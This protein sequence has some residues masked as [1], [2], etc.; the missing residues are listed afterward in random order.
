MSM[1][2]YDFPLSANCW[3]VRLVLSVY[4]VAYERRT[5]DLTRGAHLSREYRAVNP[6]GQTPALVADGEV[7]RDS[8]VICL[9]LGERFGA[10]YWPADPQLRRAIA[11]WMFFD[12]SDLH[13]GVGLARN[14]YLFGVGADGDGPRARGERALGAMERTLRAQP[15]LCGENPTLAD[16][17]C[18]PFAALM[19]EARIDPAGFPHVAAWRERIAALPGYAPMT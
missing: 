11:A 15:W 2:L 5:V 18:Y 12:A 14:H 7:I 9:Y 10:P 19:H 1:I 4:G 16:L 6:L 13:G 3:R 8:H 17:A